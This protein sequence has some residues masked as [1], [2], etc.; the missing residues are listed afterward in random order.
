MKIPDNYE[1][2]HLNA[3]SRGESD[4]LAP[5]RGILNGLALAAICWGVLGLA[6]W[7]WRAIR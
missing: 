3:E 4:D 1:H 6:V 5:A 7:A 2:L